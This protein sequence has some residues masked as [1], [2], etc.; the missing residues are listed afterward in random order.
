MTAS[1]MDETVSRHSVNVER[2][3]RTSTDDAKVVNDTGYKQELKRQLTLWDVASFM[4][5][6][7]GAW[8]SALSVLTI[9]FY[10][11]GFS[12]AIY[13][14]LG[15]TPVIVCF[16]GCLSEMISTY[17]TAGGQYHFVA[18]LAPKKYARGL[19]FI[20]GYLSLYFWI[21]SATSGMLSFA[22]QIFQMAAYFNPEIA[23]L[24]RW[25]QVATAWGLVIFSFLSSTFYVRFV[26]GMTQFQLY[27]TMAVF[28]VLNVLLLVKTKDKNSAK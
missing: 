23:E 12:S 21:A 1:A 10:N 19:S 2:P 20:C 15:L 17:P 7:G 13:G 24:S 5:N 3:S 9:P 22:Q 11:G 14:V 26:T 18:I 25:T 4:Y 16:V 6:E 28:V 27:F 8:V